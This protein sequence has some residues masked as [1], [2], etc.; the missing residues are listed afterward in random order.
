MTAADLRVRLERLRYQHQMGLAGGLLFSVPE[1]RDAMFRE[2]G[3][4]P[5]DVI[6]TFAA[7]GDGLAKTVPVADDRPEAEIR[8]GRLEL[9]ELWASVIALGIGQG[10]KEHDFFGSPPLFEFARHVRNAVA[11]GGRFD[12]RHQRGP[13]VWETKVITAE[14]DDTAL[15]EFV[16]PNDIISLLDDVIGDLA[17]R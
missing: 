9:M 10:L 3:A 8:R 2:M 7:R 14:L 13:A 5:G 6:S 17:K 15:F 12:I 16:T 11:H 1:M 4:Q